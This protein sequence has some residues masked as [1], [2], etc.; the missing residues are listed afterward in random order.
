[1]SVG[2][3]TECRISIGSF[4]GLNGCPNCGAT[5]VPCSNEN[6]V[7]VSINWHELHC[8]C[9]WAENYARE[10]GFVGTVYSIAH[11]LEAQYP[12]RHPL[13]LSGEI[14]KIKGAKLYDSDGKEVR[15]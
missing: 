13:T 12:E 6:Q 9:V 10:K 3:C 2:F 8:L 14:N 7:M 15:S 1:M 4:E 11:A 5:T